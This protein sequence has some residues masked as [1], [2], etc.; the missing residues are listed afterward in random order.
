M[1]EQLIELVREHQEI[2]DMSHKKYMDTHH[3]NKV[4]NE[5][6]ETLNTGEHIGILYLILYCYILY[7]VILP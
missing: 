2:Y 4:W 7:F 5:I 1:D 3:K 6:G